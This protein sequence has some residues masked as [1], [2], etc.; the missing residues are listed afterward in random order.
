MET[1]TDIME[2]EMAIQNKYRELARKEYEQYLQR[3]ADS[4]PSVGCDGWPLVRMRTIGMQVMTSF[5]TAHLRVKN[6]QCHGTGRYE[7]PFRERC[8]EGVRG[9]VS[10]AFEL[11]LAATAMETGS[12]EKASRL[13]R[14]WG[15]AVSDDKIMD[16]VRGV[17]GR[18]S[19]EKLPSLCDDAA[20]R[21]DTLVVMMDGWFARHRG[22]QW[23]C[24]G[25]AESV[26]S[27]GR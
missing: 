7:T 10:P 20:G 3:L 14:E 18:C 8:F 12:F 6:G 9:C 27:G 2:A 15:C 16:V 24:G 11:K 5:G 25:R 17:S 19:E 23:G 21:E 1:Y 4:I 22:P 13:C 26:A